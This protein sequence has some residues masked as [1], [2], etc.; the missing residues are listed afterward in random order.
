MDGCYPVVL[1]YLGGALAACSQLL[2]QK[3]CRQRPDWHFH[4]GLGGKAALPSLIHYSQDFCACC[5]DKG[6]KDGDDSCTQSYDKKCKKVGT[7]C[8]SVNPDVSVIYRATGM[9]GYAVMHCH[10]SAIF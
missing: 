8:L 7:T 1:H 2:L 4:V 9:D 5:N 6:G 3:S 10:R